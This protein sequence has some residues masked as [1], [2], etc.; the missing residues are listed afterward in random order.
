M[1]W[2]KRYILLLA[3]GLVLPSCGPMSGDLR[4]CES[5]N[6]DTLAG[7]NCKEAF[8]AFHSILWFRLEKPTPFRVSHIEV[9]LYR[10]NG[11]AERPVDSG[12]LDVQP[13]WSVFASQ[14]YVTSQGHYRVYILDPNGKTM[15]KGDF[16]VK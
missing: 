1:K 5:V 8:S 2:I 11:E 12:T 7:E 10:V 4:F 9:R 6:Q 14:F 15:A 3:V 13:E 16:R